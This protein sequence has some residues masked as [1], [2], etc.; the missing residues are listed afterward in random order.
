MTR[1]SPSGGVP[2]QKSVT[3]SRNSIT[4]FRTY[5]IDF[6][7]RKNTW[8]IKPDAPLEGF[9][10]PSRRNN[11]A[12]KTDSE[13]KLRLSTFADRFSGIRDEITEQRMRPIRAR[14]KFGMI[15]R[16]DHERMARDFR[17]FDQ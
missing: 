12:A 13:R 8:I 16:P 10:L 11:Q 9:G 7:T 1:R 15:L 5:A 3:A 6:C 4:C 17:D 2:D 14:P